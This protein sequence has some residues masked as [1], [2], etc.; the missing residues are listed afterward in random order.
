MAESGTAIKK[1]VIPEPILVIRP[2]PSATLKYQTDSTAFSQPDGVIVDSPQRRT[3][4]MIREEFEGTG[5]PV[6]FIR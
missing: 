4:V 6:S 3:G 2:A 1:L 5:I